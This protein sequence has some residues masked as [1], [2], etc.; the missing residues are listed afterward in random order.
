MD[1]VNSWNINM[2][3]LGMGNYQLPKILTVWGFAIQTGEEKQGYIFLE[4]NECVRCWYN[5]HC[6]STCRRLSTIQAESVQESAFDEA[7]LNTFGEKL[8]LSEMVSIKQGT[9]TAFGIE[10][11]QEFAAFSLIWNDLTGGGKE[12]KIAP[13]VMKKARI[14]A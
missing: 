13:A 1:V 7:F 12:D 2:S 8:L 6:D 4:E 9:A 5:A 3:T 10:D 14:M 11:M